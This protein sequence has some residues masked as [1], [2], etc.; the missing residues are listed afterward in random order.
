MPQLTRTQSSLNPLL[1]REISNHHIATSVSAILQ[2]LAN[3][4]AGDL[5]GQS[6]LFADMEERDAHIFAEMTKRKNAV[7]GLDWTLTSSRQAG[8]RDKKSVLEFENMIR[9]SIDTETLVFDLADAIGKGFACLEITWQ[10]GVNGWWL[11][12]ALT[13]RPQRWFTTDQATREQIRLRNQSSYE[14][15]ELWPNGWIVHR[16]SA[17]AGQMPTQGLYRVLALPYLFKNFAIKNWLRFTELYGVPIRVLFH[18]ETDATRKLE[19]QQALTNLGAAGVALLQGGTQDD[20]VTVEAATGEG[21]GFLNLIEWAEKSESKAILGGTLTS[22]ADGKTSTNALGS[23]HDEV[24]L[25]IRSHDAKQIAATLT[26]QLLGAIIRVNG[27]SISATWAFDTTEPEDLALYADALPKLAAIEGMGIPAAWAHEKLKI[28]L[29]EGDEPVLSVAKQAN[30]DQA[31]TKSD[32]PGQTGLSAGHHCGVRLAA[33]GKPVFTPQQQVIEDIG[34]GLL[35]A[36]SGPIPDDLIKAAI[37]AASDPQDLK[38]R[39]AAILLNADTAEF[40]RVLE[41]ALFTADVL[42]YAHAGGH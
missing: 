4:E 29:P 16:H 39:L 7:A 5:V 38:N 41:R 15:E 11:P 20:L 23:V 9:D 12:A 35:E 36:L 22:Q 32:K 30:P 42:G 37:K 13:P 21:Q 33:D 3:A 6:E 19:L 26:T 24:R 25:M 28:P 31:G 17:K 8:A 1:Q 34:D 18:H 27:L 40:R 14:G 2:L 10:R